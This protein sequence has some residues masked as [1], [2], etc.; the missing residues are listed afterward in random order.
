MR[1]FA[2][3]GVASL[4]LS[5][6][7]SANQSDSGSSGTGGGYGASSSSSAGTTADSGGSLSVGV[8][9]GAAAGSVMLEPS[10]MPGGSD[11]E[12]GECA[13]QDFVLASKPADVLLVL[14][15]SKSMIE[16]TVPPMDQTRWDAVVG[17][18]TAVIT[19]TDTSVA[20]GL[21]LFP[22]GEGSS[23]NA[24]SVTEAVPIAIA[25]NNAAR[26]NAAIMGTMALGNGT[27]TGDA[28]N[29]AREYLSSRNVSNQY[30]VLA[31]DGEPSCPSDDDG[32]ALEYA[33]DAIEAAK[34]A[35][36]PTYVIGVVDADE[37]DDTARRLDE[38]AEAG[39]TAR[40]GA[41]SGAKFFAAYSQE[42][43][44]KALAAV[45]GAVASCVFPFD[46]APPDPTNIAVKVNGVRIDQDP[47]RAGGW[48]YTDAAHSGLELHGAA[49][50][51]IKDAGQNQVSII[52]GCKGRPIK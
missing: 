24:S 3:I 15:R 27:P 38:M 7:C 4:A 6:A 41:P 26:M 47:S 31:T 14:D 2:S 29:K 39:G 37:D 44:A 28:I 51:A 46:A 8:G 13:Q 18:L 25:A 32:D 43:L 42:E 11:V 33:I 52:F 35:G 40:V 23:C 5:L 10:E 17:G 19:A 50:Q 34:A 45:T 12:N 20:W 9:V 21:K 16:H 22:E 30:L 1:L 36:F 48:D 49:C